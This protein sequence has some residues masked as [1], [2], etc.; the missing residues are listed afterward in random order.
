MGKRRRRHI[1]R[2][3]KE[4][5][6]AEKQTIKASL[7]H[8]NSV[9]QQKLAEIKKNSE[10]LPTENKEHTNT[11]VP[12]LIEEPPFVTSQ[13]EKTEVKKTKAQPKKKPSLTVTPKKR[14]PRRKRTKSSK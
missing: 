5:Q 8:E 12:S 7:M 4:K 1:L 9:A 3:V 2:L 11:G 6:E 10:E 14:T 13:A